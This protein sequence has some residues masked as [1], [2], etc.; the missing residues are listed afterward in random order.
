[1]AVEEVIAVGGEQEAREA[2]EV[3][4]EGLLVERNA[5]QAQEVV[6]EVVQVPGDGLAV[7]AGARV[8]DL[9]VEV[10]AGHYL[11]LWQCGDG[12]AIGFN[13]FRPDGVANAVAGEEFKERGVAEVFFKIDAVVKVFF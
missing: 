12:A 2:V 6:L 7:E 11:K 13:G 3:V 8:A 5:S 4:F 9:V 1:I 10:A